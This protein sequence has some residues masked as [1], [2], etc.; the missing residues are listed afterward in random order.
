MPTTFRPA[1]R[2]N[3]P[4]KTSRPSSNDLIDARP[5]ARQLG[6]RHDGETGHTP[7]PSGKLARAAT[8][9]PIQ[10]KANVT[11]TDVASQAQP[12]AKR[13]KDKASGPTKLFVLDTNV[14]MH[15]PMCLFRFEEHDIF[16]R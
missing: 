9:Q 15:D 10:L 3:Q 14:L 11:A 1:V 6:D 4:K 12:V 13:K 5:Q 7:P 16:C 8:S 2:P